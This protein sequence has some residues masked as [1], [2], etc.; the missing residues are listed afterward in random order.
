[1]SSPARISAKATYETLKSNRN[2]RLV[3][4]YPHAKWEASHL[5]G[6]ISMAT[7]ESELGSLPNDACLVFY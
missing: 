2:S 5:D 1:M 4:V 6:S 7:L 3:C